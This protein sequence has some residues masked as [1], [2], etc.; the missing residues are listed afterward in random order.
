MTNQPAHH[1]TIVI[2]RS[3][4]APVRTVY[5][6]WADPVRRARWDFP[7]DGWAA[8]QVEN[9]FAIGGRKVSRFGPP[10]ETPYVE[11]LRYEDI[12]PG[13]RIV[14]AYSISRGEARI[15]ASLATVEFSGEAARTDMKLT[16][17]IVILDGGEKPND[18]ERGWGEAL[19]KLDRELAATGQ[20]TPA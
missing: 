8:E 14:F 17:Q 3:F 19:D 4:G 6:C 18:R 5:E 2:T 1:A 12:V 15:T 13:R 9:R 7:G 10:G 16:E 11:D 20:P